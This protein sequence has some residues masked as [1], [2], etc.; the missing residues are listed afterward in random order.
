MLFQDSNVTGSVLNN[1]SE[2]SN[3]AYS[4]IDHLLR[5]LISRLPFVAAGIL[6]AALFY[7]A[8]RLIR[9][10]FL[11]A[12]KRTNLDD[13][14]RILF[15]RLLMVSVVVMGIFTAFTVIIPTFGFG[16]L[17]AGIGLTSFVIGFATK[18]ILNNLLSGVLILWQQPFKV[19]DQI[20]IDKLQGRVEYIGVRAT[21]LRKDDGELVLVPN[22]DMYSGTLTIRGAG[23][24]RRMGLEVVI[25][26]D[27][28]VAK[29]KDAIREALERSEGVVSEPP[30]NIYVT[31]LAA[32]GV[33]MMI[34]FWLN[35]NEAR[36]RK[37]FDRAACEVHN[38]L[39]TAGIGLYPPTSMIIQRQDAP[40]PGEGGA[41][42]SAVR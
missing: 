2:V 41:A 21:S 13:R 7:L 12:S 3:V 37:V 10:I 19:G 25:G 5:S 42:S 35:A 8:A 30:P 20:F 34:N 29:A 9:Y 39:D 33:K 22:G 27:D 24:K 28:D 18:D 14:L 1:A 23:E 26:Y 31:D 16:D 38:A 15:S 17:V 6:V 11:A 36:P 32:E 40:A 4:S